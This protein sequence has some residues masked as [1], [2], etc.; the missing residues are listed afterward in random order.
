MQL[1]VPSL[2]IVRLPGVFLA[3]VCLHSDEELITRVTRKRVIVERELE[4]ALEDKKV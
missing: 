4:I 1:T 3:C 2:F